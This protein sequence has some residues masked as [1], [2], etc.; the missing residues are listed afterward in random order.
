[1][2]RPTEPAEPTAT[3]LHDSP[4]VPPQWELDELDGLLE[5]LA[6]ELV[7]RYL[8]EAGESHGTTT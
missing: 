2:T 1:M 3:E 6:K 4:P 7:E 8:A 5:V